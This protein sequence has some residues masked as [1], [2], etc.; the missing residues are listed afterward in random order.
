MAI[1]TGTM[2][3]ME[4]MP[5]TTT[6]IMPT[7]KQFFTMMPTLKLDSNLAH[8][9]PSIITLMVSSSHHGK[10]LFLPYAIFT[11]QITKCIKQN[12]YN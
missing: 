9:I 12:L 3:I 10:F 2:A 4:T 1:L 8:Q 6:Q 7:I 11:L 5:S